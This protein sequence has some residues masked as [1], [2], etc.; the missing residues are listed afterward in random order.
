MTTALIMAGVLLVSCAARAQTTASAPAPSELNLEWNNRSGAQ[1]SLDALA[2]AGKAGQFKT[3]VAQGHFRIEGG[4]QNAMPEELRKTEFAIAIQ[5]PAARLTMLGTLPEF[6]ATVGVEAGGFRPTGPAGPSGIRRKLAADN[7]YAALGQ[8]AILYDALREYQNL[9]SSVTFKAGPGPTDVADAPTGLK[10]F[11]L[12]QAAE[13]PHFVL[14]DT[15]TVWLGLD[16]QSGLPRMIVGIRKPPAT[17]A[18]G[19]AAAPASAGEPIR[20]IVTFDQIQTDVPIK[21]ENLLL[22]AEA[23]GA[24]WQDQTSKQATSA[25]ASFLPAKP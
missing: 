18:T 25:P 6:R 9:M 10:W 23:A 4:R 13:R 20:M 7:L 15:K 19:A 22:P 11:E 24:I 16:A 14:K 8:A 2:L 5:M 1:Q 12:V 21:P 17:P 3:L